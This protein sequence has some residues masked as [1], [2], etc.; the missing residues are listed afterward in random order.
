MRLLFAILAL[1]QLAYTQTVEFSLLRDEELQN[2]LN[3]AT[4]VNKDRFDALAR[5]FDQSGCTSTSVTVQP[6]K[7]AKT[8]NIICTLKGA[9]PDIILITAHYDMTGPGMRVVDN[10][11]GATML[12]NLYA[13]LSAVLRQHTIQ[14]AGFTDEEV[15][16]VGSRFFVSQA[17]KGALAQIKAVINIDSI[18]M[19]P[20]SVWST[21][22]D[23]RLLYALRQIETAMKL[24]LAW[25]SADQVGDTDSHPFM[26]KK[27]PVIDFH[28]LTQAT[29]PILHSARDQQAAIHFEDYSATYRA[30]AAYIAFLDLQL[31]TILARKVK[32]GK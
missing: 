8:P 11:T 20:V 7:H 32:I 13:A 5:L 4:R 28:S 26:N 29:F 22:A 19:G 27:V 23:P 9:S 31:E 10:W 30:L 6:V 15:D 3:L 2:R 24:D 25:V 1:G 21:R 12:A 14:F 16:L 17:G 18:G